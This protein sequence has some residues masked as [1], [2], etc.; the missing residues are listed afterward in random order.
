[1]AKS[2]RV[3]TR[4]HVRRAA[5]LAAF[6]VLPLAGL[7]PGS[8]KADPSV[9]TA[10]LTDVAEAWYATA[11]IDVCTTPLGCP[12]QQVPT[13][14]YPAGSLHVGVAGGQETARTYLLPALASLPTGATLLSG[15]M[16]MHVDT[17]QADG[18]LSPASAKILACLVTAPFTDGTA[19]A[20]AAAPATDCTTSAK[21]TYDASGG[22]LTLDLDTFLHAWNAGSPQLGIAL[23]PNATQTT[24]TDA[25]HLTIEGRRQSGAKPVTSTISYRPPPADEIPGVTPLVP[26]AVPPAAPPSVPSVGSLPPATSAGGATGPAPV[27]AAQPATTGTVTRPVAFAGPVTTPAAFLAPLALLAGLVFFARLFTRDVTPK[28]VWS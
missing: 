1:M 4:R 24:Q 3:S 21:P 25:W 7:L 5:L 27:V 9:S 22:V 13:S 26:A 10:T 17:S 11:P 2:D 20:T 6:I 12:P 18:T 8:A 16:T 15:T 28:R 23:V 14:P 19:G